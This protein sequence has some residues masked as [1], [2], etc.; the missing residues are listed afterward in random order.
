ME[1]VSPLNRDPLVI[2]IRPLAI[3]VTVLWP[4]SSSSLR[5]T[6]CAAFAY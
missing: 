3:G 5:L 6:D 1:M 2:N 4:T